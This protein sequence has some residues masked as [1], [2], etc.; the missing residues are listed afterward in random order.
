MAVWHDP[1]PASQMAEPLLEWL[2]VKASTAVDLQVLRDAQVDVRPDIADRLI[3]NLRAYVLAEH[4]ASTTQTDTLNVPA[5][6]WDHWKIDHPWAEDWSLRIFWSGKGRHRPR[7]GRWLTRW[8][9]LRPAAYQ[10][11]TLTT[12]WTERAI[13]PHATLPRADPRL[14]PAVLW[15][16]ATTHLENNRS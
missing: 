12:T 3:V 15:R 10:A 13:Y 16:D 11:R 6:W 4:L 2:K 14:G 1:N 8:L 9:W 7:F 5:T